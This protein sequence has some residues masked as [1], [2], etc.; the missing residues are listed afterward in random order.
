MWIGSCLRQQVCLCVCKKSTFLCTCLSIFAIQRSSFRFHIL[1]FSDVIGAFFLLACSKE[2][3]RTV[4]GFVSENVHKKGSQIHKGSNTKVSKCCGIHD[5]MFGDEW[6]R[7]PQKK[8]N[9]YSEKE[10]SRDVRWCVG[11]D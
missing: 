10:D 1:I 9:M 8:L 3:D 4:K 11:V 5:T 7:E 2:S 6:K